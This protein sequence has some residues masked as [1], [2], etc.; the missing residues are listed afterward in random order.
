LPLAMAASPSARARTIYSARAPLAGDGSDDAPGNVDYNLVHRTV[1]VYGSLMAEEVVDALLAP[2]SGTAR[3]GLRCTR[4][5]KVFGYGRWCLKVTGTTPRSFSAMPGSLPAGPLVRCDGHLL[6]RLQPSELKCIDSFHDPRFERIV[7]D[8]HAE[9]GFGGKEVVQALMYV[10]PHASGDLL[11][12]SKP[13]NY[14]EFRVKEMTKFIE[15][16]AKPHRKRF[17]EEE[18]TKN[19]TPAAAPA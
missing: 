17:E 12:T 9:D 4:P 11:D 8:V 16:V 5:G 14:Q 19:S 3:S 2:G 7:V 1:F 15:E 10:C 6:E 13:W 18:A